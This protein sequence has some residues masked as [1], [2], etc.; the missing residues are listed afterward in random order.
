MNIAE[1]L[2]NKDLLEMEDIVRII[3]ITDYHMLETLFKVDF[4]AQLPNDF[5]SL[6]IDMYNLCKHVQVTVLNNKKYKNVYNKIYNN[7]AK[8]DDEYEN[9]E[10]F[11]DDFIQVRFE[12]MLNDQELVGYG[13]SFVITKEGKRYFYQLHNIIRFIKKED[14]LEEN[15]NRVF[16]QMGGMFSGGSPIIGGLDDLFKALKDGGGGEE[17]KK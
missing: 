1:F 2:E 11:I 6:N 15:Q 17:S 9:L 3:T 5:E 4:Y 8:K 7:L 10:H 13:D 16:E 12:A 14:E